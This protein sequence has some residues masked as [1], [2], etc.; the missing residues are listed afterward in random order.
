MTNV[1]WRRFQADRAAAASR[2]DGGGGGGGG[3]CNSNNPDASV[4]SA[5]DVEA[6]FRNLND[7]IRKWEFNFGRHLQILLDALNHYAATETVVLLSLCA[8]LSTVNQGTEFTGLKAD[9]DSMPAI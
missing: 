7:L 3:N 8:R 9:D 4:L 6:R 2:K 1:Q 5:G